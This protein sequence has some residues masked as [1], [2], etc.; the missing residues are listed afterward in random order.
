MYAQFSESLPG[1]TIDENAKEIYINTDRST[2][3]RELEAAYEHYL[4]EDLDYFAITED[5]AAGLY[6][7]IRRPSS[8]FRIPP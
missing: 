3:S 7:F 1:V 4:L 8:V 6:E 5:Y 2:Y